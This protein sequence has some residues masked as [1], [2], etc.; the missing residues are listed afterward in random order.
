MT[1]WL[2]FDIGT[3]GTKAALIDNNGQ[4]LRSV[5]RAYPTHTA[6]GG[7][8]EQDPALWWQAACDSARELGAESAEAICVTGQ[9]QDLIL[10]NAAGEPIRPAILYSDGRAH[11]QVSHLNAHG[12]AAMWQAL[13]GNDQGAGSLVAKLYWLAQHEPESLQQAAH[14]LTGAADL[15][16]YRLTGTA[17]SDTTT[18]STTGLL[19]LATRTWIDPA[20]LPDSQVAQLLPRLVA[21]GTQIGTLTTSSAG[22]LGI[23]AGL[24]VHLGPGDAGATTL[25]S[26]SG[27][28]GVPYG[29]VGTSGWIAYTTPQRGDPRTGVFTLAHPQPNLYICIAPLLTAGGN[30]DWARDLFNAESHASLIEAALARPLTNLLYLPYLNGERSP[31]SDPFARG[32]FIGLTAGHT[33]ADLSRAVLEGVAFAYHHAVSALLQAPAERLI[34]TGGGTRSPEWCQVLA[35]VTGVRIDIATDAA[36]TGL[37]GA[38]VAAEVAQGTR[39]SYALAVETVGESLLPRKEW[40][41]RYAQKERWYLQAYTSLKGLFAQMAE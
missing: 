9:M 15:I 20:L 35:D 2:A 38:I 26:G 21:G 10:I 34:L 28:V 18:A 11:A 6:Q 1:V 37:R 7:I 39:N 3:T 29:Y 5:Y 31:F 30:F 23:R 33:A 27:V 32:A 24:P 13:T 25:G 22:G 16:A 40:T 36:N 8:V 14:L 12:D 19:D 17:A 41:A 4:V